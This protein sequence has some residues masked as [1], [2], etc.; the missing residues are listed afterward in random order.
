[1]ASD[2][3]NI[4]RY[5]EEQLGKDR[6]SRMSQ[7]AMYADTAHFVY[8][9]LQ[10]AD[11]AGATEI[12]FTVSAEQLVVE[13]DGTPFNE[14]NVRGISYFGK[15]K[16]DITKIGHFGLGFKS[17]FAYTASPRV[18]SDKESFEISQLYSVTATQ[19]PTDLK[20]RRTRFV[21]PF[22][23]LSKIPDYIER[24]KLKS[25]EKAYEEI[26]D[27]LANL[28]EESLLFTQ[29]LTEIHWT[30]EEEEGHYLREDT[31]VGGGGHVIYIVTGDSEG[32]CYLVFDRSIL[33]PDEDGYE[34]EHRPVQIAFGLDKS[35][36]EEGVIEDVGDARLFVFFP[37]DKETHIGFILQGPY[38]TTPARD[39]VPPDD[40]FNQHLVKE[41]ATLLKISLLNLKKLGLLSLDA[42]ATLPLN[43]ER[44]REGSFLYPLYAEVRDALSNQP[45]LPTASRGFVSGS[46]A[47]LARGAELTKI[48][49]PSQLE[50]LF[51]M[52]DLKWLDS[53]LT[54]NNHPEL[55]RFMV[56]KKSQ[57]VKYFEKSEWI[58]PPLAPDIEV[59]AEQIAKRINVEFMSR[60][61]DQ[62][63]LR[64]YEYLSGAKNA[65]FASQPIIRLEMDKH[66]IPFDK[67]GTPNAFLP[68]V[69]E[70]EDEE[71]IIDLPTVKQS[72]VKREEIREFLEFDIGLTTPDMT[73]LVIKKVLT[74]Y[75]RDK[76][77][78]SVATWQRDF[79]KVLQALQTD[80]YEKRGRL[81]ELLEDANFLL[82]ETSCDKGGYFKRIKN[83]YINSYEITIFFSGCECIYL[84]A[85]DQ[86]QKNDIEILVRLGLAK[87]PRIKARTANHLGHVTLYSTHG[88][89]KRGLDRFDPDWEMEGLEDAVD[90]PS[91]QRSQL[92]WEYLLP[93]SSYIR[94]VI[95]TSGRQSFERIDGH[96]EVISRLGKLLI[97]KAWLPDRDGGLHAPADIALE[98]L[99]P[100]YDKN[101]PS[102]KELARKLGMRK[103][104]E[105]QALAVLTGGDPKRKKLLEFM[106][107]ADDATLEKFDKL[108]P[109]E[110]PP[111]EF[112]T[113]KEGVSAIH[114]TQRQPQVDISASTGTVSNPGKYLS[115]LDE[116]TKGSVR[117]ALTHSITHNS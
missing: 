78:I 2:Y 19:F 104:E 60:Q 33:W 6:A 58:V 22:D 67:K 9:L 59:T 89:H 38:R 52:P 24:R 17:V 28:G 90:N 30:T 32:R 55:H 109:K 84:L 43:H 92:L 41:S 48:F 54:Q 65:A 36:K 103:S 10:N 4:T 112:K 18:H 64:F 44:F 13:H 61:T 66:V 70:D 94:G 100:G 25:A 98:D 101:T 117:E 63:V 11:D 1:M 99:P 108:I 97:E 3:K 93:C 106:L 35:L 57:P 39:N 73:D 8:E 16:T 81:E 62:W 31:P 69:D 86:Y 102:A 42:L 75:T 46:Q 83:V 113:F 110:K 49:G 116:V 56:G 29:S 27:K 68:P 14:E 79:R 20:R 34:V 71:T 105:Q 91:L 76:V 77:E 50:Q 47:K 107:H 7:V 88:W 114:R 15:E 40:D 82:A 53:E 111:S 80:S 74:K 95:E 26:A 96:E 23:H 5:N 12:Y 87:S 51:G 115:S 72:L 85:Q 45:L 21:L 37:T